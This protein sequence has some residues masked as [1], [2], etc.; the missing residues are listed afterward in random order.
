[1]SHAEIDHVH[2]AFDQ[3]LRQATTGQVG[4]TPLSAPLASQLGHTPI[5]DGPF[6]FD[7]RLVGLAQSAALNAL[8][9]QQR[10]LLATR[11][12]PVREQD[13]T[14]RVL[15]PFPVGGCYT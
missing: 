14:P 7:Q 15:S 13:H 2:R 9:E 1:M 12:S 10:N 5:A 6:R 4:H 3:F 8:E 11:S